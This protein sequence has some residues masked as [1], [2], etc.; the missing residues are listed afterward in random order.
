MTA[1]PA[2]ELLVIDALSQAFESIDFIDYGVESSPRIFKRALDG[3]DPNISIG[4]T[5]SGWEPQENANISG[6]EPA[7]ATYSFVIQTLI[8]HTKRED[9]EHLGAVLANRLRRMLYR[10]Q[11]LR[12]SL[13]SISVLSGEL[14]ERVIRIRVDRQECVDTA[15]KGG[16]AFMSSTDFRVTTEIA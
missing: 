7:M 11:D 16:F 1:V 14:H 6:W 4:V 2:I 8:K 15:F 3:A 10:D 12:I 5:F 9:G 13:Y